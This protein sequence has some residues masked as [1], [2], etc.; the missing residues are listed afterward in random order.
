MHND[1]SLDVIICCSSYEPCRRNAATTRAPPDPCRLWLRHH[2][3]LSFFPAELFCILLISHLVAH[4]TILYGEYTEPHRF[5]DLIP[6]CQIPNKSDRDSGTCPSWLR[7]ARPERQVPLQPKHQ[8]D[9]RHRI[10]RRC[11]IRERRVMRSCMDR[12]RICWR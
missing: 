3:H 4:T 2:I 9:S 11:R 12:L 7:R 1:S 5:P 8:E 6:T 10:W